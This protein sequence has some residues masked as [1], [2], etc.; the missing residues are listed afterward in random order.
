M[1]A[2]AS[3]AQAERSINAPHPTPPHPLLTC[4]PSMQLG[5][6]GSQAM[7]A[8]SS[9]GEALHTSPAGVAAAG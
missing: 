9:S 8:A 7:G 2:A 1:P 5:P 6:A 4:T 3:A